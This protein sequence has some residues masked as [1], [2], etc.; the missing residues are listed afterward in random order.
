MSWSSFTSS[1]TTAETPAEKLPLELVAWGC[2]MDWRFV[3][4]FAG[5][6]SPTSELGHLLPDEP[7][8]AEASA[9][10]VFR[11]QQAESHSA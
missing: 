7:A 5:F 6:V 11:E 10:Q 2:A 9:Q 3:K 8:A 1:R 4:E